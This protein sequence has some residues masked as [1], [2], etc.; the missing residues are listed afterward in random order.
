MS[1]TA[2]AVMDVHAH[3][4][5]TEVIGMLG[6]EY[7]SDQGVLDIRMAVPCNSLSTGMQCEMDPGIISNINNLEILSNKCYISL[8]FLME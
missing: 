3:I 6:G 1:N 5:K 8:L 7:C 2:V 4:S